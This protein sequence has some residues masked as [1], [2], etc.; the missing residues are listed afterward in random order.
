[1]MMADDGLVDAKECTTD[2]GM[3]PGGAVNDGT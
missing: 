1:M 3:C 2:R